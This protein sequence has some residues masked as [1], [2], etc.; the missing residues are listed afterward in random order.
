M[1]NTLL[2]HIDVGNTQATISRARTDCTKLLFHLDFGRFS[3]YVKT[4]LKLIHLSSFFNGSKFII[5][6]YRN[7]PRHKRGTQCSLSPIP[8]CFVISIWLL[9][10]VWFVSSILRRVSPVFTL[11]ASCISLV[12]DSVCVEPMS[13]LLFSGL[14]LLEL[15]LRHLP[16]HVNPVRSIVD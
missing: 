11:I 8:V 13:E 16:Q 15:L 1:F 5:L 10:P 14:L 12:C 7:V 2:S 4:W 6:R 9:K 3:L